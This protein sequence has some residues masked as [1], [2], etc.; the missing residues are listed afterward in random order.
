MSCNIFVMWLNGLCE[1]KYV[2]RAQVKEEA[3]VDI[4]GGTHARQGERKFHT[5]PQGAS[6]RTT[7]SMQR[8]ASRT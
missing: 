8:P 5:W 3:A 1:L 6:V 2:N 4:R 7:P